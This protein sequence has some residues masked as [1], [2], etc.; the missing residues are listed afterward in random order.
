MKYG[1]ILP[2]SK[3][4]LTKKNKTKF[5]AHEPSLVS[6]VKVSCKTRMH[7]ENVVIISV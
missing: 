3:V 6:K 2:K 4:L 7:D 1:F 5:D